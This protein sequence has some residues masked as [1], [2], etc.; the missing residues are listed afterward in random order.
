MN[1]TNKTMLVYGLIDPRTNELRYI[2][3]SKSGLQRPKQ[4]TTIAK[5]YRLD[6]KSRH[7]TYCQAWLQVLVLE[8]FQ[9]E[10]LVIEVCNNAQELDDAEIFYIAYYRS[11]GCRLTNIQKGG[12][13][14]GRGM[15][16]KHTPE[17]IEKLK[18]SAKARYD[19]DPSSLQ[20]AVSI[21]KITRIGCKQSKECIAKRQATRIAKGIYAYPYHLIALNHLLRKPVKDQFGNKYQSVTEAAKAIGSSTSNIN[22]QIKGI[23]S[24]NKGYIF[25]FDGDA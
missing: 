18:L 21:N 16:Y 9:P 4:H 1:V 24:Q 13:H 14:G 2:G 5:L 12:Y 25:K 8:G 11:I 20:K 6:R 15:G 10:I 22:K 17:T 3:R 23:I 19:R 7:F